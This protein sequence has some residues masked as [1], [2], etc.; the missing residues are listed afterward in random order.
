MHTDPMFV[1][2]TVH[3]VIPFSQTVVPWVIPRMVE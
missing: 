2:I 1:W 3:V